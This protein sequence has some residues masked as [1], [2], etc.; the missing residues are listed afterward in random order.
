MGAQHGDDALRG[1]FGNLA[2]RLEPGGKQPLGG[3]E[4]LPASQLDAASTW[5]ELVE[6]EPELA[7]LERRAAEIRDTGGAFFCANDAWFSIKGRLAE[8]LGVWRRPRKGESAQ[9]ARALADGGSFELVFE[10]LYPLL[11]P[12]RDCGCELFEPLRRLT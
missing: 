4:N 6:L 5:E 11:P 10:R 2:Q 1:R 7:A 8:L 3:F 9:A 12:C